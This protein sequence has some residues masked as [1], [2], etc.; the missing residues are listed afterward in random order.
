MSKVMRTVVLALMLASGLNSG[1]MAVAD[2]LLSVDDAVHGV[3]SITRDPNTGLDWLDLTETS[4]RSFLDIDSQ[5]C[6]GCEFDGFRHASGAE[7]FQFFVDAGIPFIELGSLAANTSPVNNLLNLWGTLDATP[8][9]LQSFALTA[10]VEFPNFHKVALL[11][12]FFGPPSAGGFASSVSGDFS[13]ANVSPRVGH[14]LVRPVSVPEP[15]TSVLLLS[16][17]AMV[18]L[19]MRK[20]AREKRRSSRL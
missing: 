6:A 8:E 2:P 19:A 1:N 12:L 17:L 7:V 10:D 9:L 13:D 4:N 5:L 15:A 3:D 18:G 14:A 11:Q 16:G 20:R